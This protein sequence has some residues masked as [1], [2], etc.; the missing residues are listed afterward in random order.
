M[1]KEQ[2]KP[3]QRYHQLYLRWKCSGKGAR[4]FCEQ[5]SIKYSTFWYWAKKFKTSALPKDE[6]IEMKVDKIEVKSSQPLAELRLTDKGA[7][8]FYEL[9]EPEWVK[10]LLS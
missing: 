6:F 4:V 7:L 1:K 10:A 8:I 9:P 3:D 5:E 2:N